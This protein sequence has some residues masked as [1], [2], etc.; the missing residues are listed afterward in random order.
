MIKE[1]TLTAKGKEFL[2]TV[3]K[4]EKYLDKPM[5]SGITVYLNNAAEEKDTGLIEELKRQVED[6]IKDGLPF[7]LSWPV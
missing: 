5:R 1:L 7:Y 6:Y 2:G 4:D 3:V